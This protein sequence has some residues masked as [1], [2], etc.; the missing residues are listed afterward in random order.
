[1]LQF[2]PYMYANDRLV[3]GR[4]E[5]VAL[6]RFL[7]WGEGAGQMTSDLTHDRGEGRGGGVYPEFS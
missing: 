7:E 2:K 4:S 3:I 6:K 1:M 5:A